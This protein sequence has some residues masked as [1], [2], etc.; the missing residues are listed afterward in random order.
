[1]P[2]CD[3]RRASYK[4]FARLVLDY[5]QG[6]MERVKTVDVAAIYGVDRRTAYRWAIILQDLAGLRFDRDGYW[7]PHPQTVT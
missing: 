6:R 2:D 4:T 7:L 5:E 3:D 1:M